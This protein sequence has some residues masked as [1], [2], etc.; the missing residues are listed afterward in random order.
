MD[1]QYYCQYCDDPKWTKPELRWSNPN[2]FKTKN[3]CHFLADLQ[4]FKMP[5]FLHNWQLF[6][7]EW[8]WMAVSR[9]VVAFS[10][11]GS[12]SKSFLLLLLPGFQPGVLLCNWKGFQSHTTC[13]LDLLVV[14]LHA[15]VQHID[16]HCYISPHGPL[17]TQKFNAYCLVCLFSSWSF[18]S[19]WCG[20]A[21]VCEEKTAVAADGRW[22]WC[23]WRTLWPALKFAPVPSHSF[24]W[25]RGQLRFP[26]W[27]K[28]KQTRGEIKPPA[29]VDTFIFGEISWRRFS[30]CEWTRKPIGVTVT[31]SSKLHSVKVRRVRSY[32][33]YVHSKAGNFHLGVIPSP[34]QLGMPPS[35]AIVLREWVG[36]GLSWK[37]KGSVLWRFF[38]R[39]TSWIILFPHSCRAE[40]PMGQRVENFMYS[41]SV[42]GSPPFTS[43]AVTIPFWR[44]IPSCNF[45]ARRHELVFENRWWPS[46]I[47]ISWPWHPD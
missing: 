30:H 34:R 10:L 31:G 26:F 3:T 16:R 40:V 44:T 4:I 6:C 22:V 17:Q 45:A 20:V 14:V 15:R 28:R 38:S 1:S 9:K 29:L 18:G 11:G 27:H 24:G 12:P 42:W 19:W 33:N 41:S 43:L 5:V 36:G 32:A 2:P 13:I 7:L 37:E 39:G 21:L 46:A 25:H 23:R 47:Y 8:P 35:I